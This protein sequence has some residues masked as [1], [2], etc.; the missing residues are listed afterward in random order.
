MKEKLIFLYLLVFPIFA[1]AASDFSLYGLTCDDAVKPL[2]MDNQKPC[3]GWKIHAE[4]R[5]F[6]QSAYQILV[7]GSM[8]DLN[9][10]V[11]DV[12]NSAKGE[13]RSNLYQCLIRAKGLMA[14][15]TY[16]WK[17]RIW[18]KSGA[19]SSWS[20][21]QTF[22]TGLLTDA[23]WRG[24]QWIA[25]QKEDADGYLVPGIHA[26][27]QSEEN[28]RRQENRNVYKLPQFRKAR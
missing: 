7:S 15:T 10:G 24:A 28:H 12:W 21:P 27:R 16:Y 14:A 19:P 6:V 11:G 5:N 1:S 23:D 20:E 4:Q 9:R 17:V 13:C 25:M 26:I 18:D 2:G 8:A 22:S 3:F